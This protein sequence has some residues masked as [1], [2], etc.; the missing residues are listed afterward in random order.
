VVRFIFR[1]A[2]RTKILQLPGV[3]VTDNKYHT[4]I[5][6]RLGNYATLQVDY[7]GKVEG[8]TGGT[9]RLMNHGGGALFAG[10]ASAL[11]LYALLENKANKVYQPYLDTR[12]SEFKMEA[13]EDPLVVDFIVICLSRHHF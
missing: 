7:A 6:E 3:N 1:L 10:K 5:I 13:K 8:S 9:T 12:N 11:L 4:I 2:G